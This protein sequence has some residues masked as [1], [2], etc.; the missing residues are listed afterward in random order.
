MVSFVFAF[1]LPLPFP[2]PLPL[3]SAFGPEVFCARPSP[4]GFSICLFP[5]LQFFGQQSGRIFPLTA[6]GR[7]VHAFRV[8]ICK[9]KSLRN[10]FR[11]G[12][13]EYF[14]RF[15]FKA[16]TRLSCSVPLLFWGLLLLLIFS[17][18]T[19]MGMYLHRFLLG[20]CT[21]NNARKKRGSEANSCKMLRA[22]GFI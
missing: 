21:F 13:F 18:S 8:L 16:F 1:A 15:C 9:T 12:K 3:C 5:V 10:V 7:V 19:L 17:F 20:Q 2:L 14:L 6:F 22:F 4:G 11:Y